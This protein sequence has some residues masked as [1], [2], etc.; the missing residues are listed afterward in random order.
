MVVFQVLFHIQVLPHLILVPCNFLLKKQGS[1]S[2][3]IFLLLIAL[4]EV[5]LACPLTAGVLC[6]LIELEVDGIQV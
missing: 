4:P 1:V 6:E 2:S 5:F 3:R